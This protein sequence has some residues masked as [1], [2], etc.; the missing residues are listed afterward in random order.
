MGQR[1]ESLAVGISLRRHCAMAATVE[2]E[3]TCWDKTHGII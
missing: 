1:I 3:R 2:P